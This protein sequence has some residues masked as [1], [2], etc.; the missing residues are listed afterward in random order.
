ME[1][2]SSQDLMSDKLRV[3]NSSPQTTEAKGP[4]GRRVVLLPAQSERSRKPL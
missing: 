4:G 2:A 1:D 3:R